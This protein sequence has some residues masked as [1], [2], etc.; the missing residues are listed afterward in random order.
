[1]TDQYEEM[2]SDLLLILTHYCPS[3]EEYE[4]FMKTWLD[5]KNRENEDTCVMYLS[6]VIYTGLSYGNWPWTVI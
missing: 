4:K 1:M 2:T 6:G 5:V 3:P